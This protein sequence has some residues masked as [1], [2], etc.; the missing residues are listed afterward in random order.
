M[1]IRQFPALANLS[2][3]EMVGYHHSWVQSNARVQYLANLY[4]YEILS[5]IWQEKKGS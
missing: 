1:E 2:N 4:T 5:L 3:G